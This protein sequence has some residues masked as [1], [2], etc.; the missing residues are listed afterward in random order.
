MEDR[1]VG[2]FAKAYINELRA[3]KREDSHGWIV[4]VQDPAGVKV[5]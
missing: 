5:S 1:K 3:G 4:P 2:A